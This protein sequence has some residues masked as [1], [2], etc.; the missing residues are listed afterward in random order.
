MGLRGVTRN[1]AMPGRWGR[2]KPETVSRHRGSREW[3]GF[4]LTVSFLPSIVCCSPPTSSHT[5]LER[6]AP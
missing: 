1:G 2:T 3:L 5:L 4:R 6:V